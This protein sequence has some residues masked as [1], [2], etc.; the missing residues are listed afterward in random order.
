MRKTI[1]L[2]TGLLFLAGTGLVFA[3][4]AAVAVKKPQ[5]VTNISKK[6]TLKDVSISK[7]LG[8]KTSAKQRV[9]LNPQPEPPGPKSDAKLQ[10]AKKVQHQTT[11]PESNSTYKK[12]WTGVAGRRRI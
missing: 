12:S 10:N 9:Q 1:I 5:N 11:L 3:E 8:I 7:K 4:N 2:T 6:L